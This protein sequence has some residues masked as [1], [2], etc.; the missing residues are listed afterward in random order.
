MVQDLI[1][2]GQV[3][4][5]LGHAILN[6]ASDMPGLA[7]V[8]LR[9]ADAASRVVLWISELPAPLITTFMVFEEF[10]RWGGLL[11][12]ILGRLGL[13]TSEPGGQVLQPV[14]V[15]RDPVQRLQ[16]H[17]DAGR[18]ADRK[19]SASLMQAIASDE[20]A[21]GRAGTAV[22]GF[23][24]DL[25]PDRGHPHVAGCPGCS[26]HRRVRVPDSEDV[27]LDRGARRRGSRRRS[28]R[29]QRPATWRW[30]PSRRT[31]WRLTRP[32]WRRRSGSRPRQRRTSATPRGRPA[33]SP[34]TTP[35]RRAPRRG[36]RKR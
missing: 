3:F 26:G 20:Y 34:R 21:F 32:G 29:R 10:S 8:L 22:K 35:R 33:G 17:P 6:F 12:T 23:G 24:E 31:P 15:R 5:N 2:I 36:T 14:A 16:G 25:E 11:V 1:E 9:I 28:G 27:G 7:E 4:G 19:V 13:A 18:H 30:P